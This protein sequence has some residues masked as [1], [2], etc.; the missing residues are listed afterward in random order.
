[1]NFLKSHIIRELSDNYPNFNRKDL[2][3][4]VN[5]IFNYIIENLAINNNVELRHFGTFK[6]KNYSER[7]GRNPKNGLLIKIPSKKRVRWKMSKQLFSLLNKKE[8]DE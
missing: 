2:S 1:M 8:Q 7:F 4:A 3:K 6:I 5:L